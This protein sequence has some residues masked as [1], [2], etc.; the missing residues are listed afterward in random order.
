[1]YFSD[2]LLL[3]EEV[4]CKSYQN[5]RA[6]LGIWMSPM[7]LSINI[8][9]NSVSSQAKVMLGVEMEATMEDCYLNF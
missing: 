9:T 4:V 5:R 2:N 8:R 6:T 1:M 3:G 7:T